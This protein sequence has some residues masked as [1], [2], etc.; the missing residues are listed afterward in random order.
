VLGY[1]L[2]GRSQTSRARE[3][4]TASG[5][6]LVVADT[7]G[8]PA[9]PLRHYTATAR[10]GDWLVIGNGDQVVPLAEALARGQ[11]VVAA[12]RAHTYEPDLP[13]WT[14]RIWM[15][16]HEDTGLLVGCARRSD[17]HDG[18]TERIIWMPE[19][20]EP[21]TGVLIT[22]YDGT[23]AQVRVD[24]RAVDLVTDTD[25]ATTLL[26][27]VWDA[28]DPRLRIAAFT[29]DPHQPHDTATIRHTVTVVDAPPGPST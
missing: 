8:G 6:D 21:G 26:D 27:L 12:W 11:D 28:L 2:T 19:L 23:A 10:R 7:A 29:V 5:G 24:G 13:I 22:T 16:W 15:A 17:L 1:F 4:R 3:I 20:T 25:N 9:D 14:P 18:S